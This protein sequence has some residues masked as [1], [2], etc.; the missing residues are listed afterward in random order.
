MQEI[1][2]KINKLNEHFR[3]TDQ[4]ESTRLLQRIVKL[5]EE[6]GELCEAVLTELDPDQRI[7]DKEIDFDGELADVM[8]V[9]LMLSTNRTKSLEDQV[10]LKLNKM[11]SKFN[12]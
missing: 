9:V 7:K 11:L 3:K 6:V 8:I 4:S 1:L 12:L 10:N 2:L 5:N